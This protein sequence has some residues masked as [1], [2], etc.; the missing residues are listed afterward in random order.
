MNCC[1]AIDF[2]NRNGLKQQDDLANKRNGKMTEQK[3]QKLVRPRG[4]E[5]RTQ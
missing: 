3:K 2:F 1:F 5:P 4:L